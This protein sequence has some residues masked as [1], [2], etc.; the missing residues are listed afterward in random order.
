MDAMLSSDWRTRGLSLFSARRLRA[1]SPNNGPGH[2]AD[3]E[4]SAMGRGEGQEVI[5]RGGKDRKDRKD[6]TAG[7]SAN[8]EAQAYL[9]ISGP[10]AISGSVP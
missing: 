2:V 5:D 6:R 7:E 9:R 3:P 4:T 8:L 10:A 1:N